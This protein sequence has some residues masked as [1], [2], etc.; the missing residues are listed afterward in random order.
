M[1]I[2]LVYCVLTGRGKGSVRQDGEKWQDT[3]RALAVS[4]I[5]GRSKLVQMI[6]KQNI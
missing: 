4:V 2:K 1:K 3:A 6:S 5:K